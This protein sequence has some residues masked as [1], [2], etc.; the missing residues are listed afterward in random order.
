[1]AVARL[2]PA[3]ESQHLAVRAVTRALFTFRALLLSLV[4]Q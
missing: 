3:E 2:E 1:M 4:A